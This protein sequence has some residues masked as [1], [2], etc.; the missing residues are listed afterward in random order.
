M[1][2]TKGIYGGYSIIFLFFFLLMFNEGHGS[3]FDNSLFFFLLI[4]LILF[5]GFGYSY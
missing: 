5:G 3:K 4:F 2:N 1:S